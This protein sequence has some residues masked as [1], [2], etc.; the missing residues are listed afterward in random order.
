MTDRTRSVLAA[1]DGGPSGRLAVVRAASIARET[2]ADLHT[3][4]IVDSDQE[5]LDPATGAARRSELRR[6]LARI[7]PRPE[8]H[9]GYGPT[10]V[11]IA[12]LAR[13][14][15]VDLIVAG[16]HRG[17]DVRRFFI[18][19]TAGQIARHGDRPVLLV[20]RAVR[21]PYR[22]IMVGVDAS[23]GSFDAIVTA[24][25]VAP[26]AT[27]IPTM[28]YGVVGESKLRRVAD[29]A[30]IAELRT[31]VAR[32][33]VEELTD[34]LASHGPDTVTCEP[35]VEIGDPNQR[36]PELPSE[37]QCD[38]IVV[39]THGRTGLRYTLLGS[40]AEHVLRDTDRDVLL[41]RRGPT[42]LQAP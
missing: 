41:A 40:V 42:V 20:R 8:L 34:F 27:I 23:P 19:T 12:Q 3:V 38:L 26:S 7:H 4:H 28:V 2:G 36:L 29:D 24:R 14:L 35:I 30:A 25:A 5:S 11:E 18:G 39:G 22:R 9:I 31:Q 16:A 33:R 15:D 13:S 21:G 1:T 6:H 10:F 17:Q 37:Y 32:Q